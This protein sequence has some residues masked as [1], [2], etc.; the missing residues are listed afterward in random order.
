VTE[1]R[2]HDFRQSD[3]NTW[4]MCPEQFRLNRAGQLPRHESDATA[5]GTAVHHGIEGVLSGQ[6]SLDEGHDL[7]AEKFTELLP[8][9]ERWNKADERTCYVHVSNCYT[10]WADQ[11]YPMLPA[12]VLVEE[13]FRV[14]L[15]EDEHRTIHLTGTV[16][17]LDELGCVWDWK[18]MG[19]EIQ[20]WEADRFKIQPTAYTY[21]ARHA[22]G[23]EEPEFAYAVMLKRAKPVDA[24]IL[25]VQR[26]EQHWEWLKRQAVSLALQIEAQLPVWHLRDQGWHCSAKWCGAWDSCKGAHL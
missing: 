1:R 6:C 20:K 22:W 14:L 7:A 2:N 23:V 21:A 19:A 5:V 4:M 12:A 17:M 26:T 13:S 8:T 25:Y 9:I 16:D 3:L 24:Q 15:H 18:N 11:V 10:T